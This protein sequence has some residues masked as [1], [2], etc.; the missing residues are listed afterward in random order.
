MGSPTFSQKQKHHWKPQ[1]PGEYSMIM[2]STLYFL[3]RPA[4]PFMT[5]HSQPSTST[6][7]MRKRT[8]IG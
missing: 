2:F 6:F 8:E 7:A 3:S 4:A 1:L 5:L